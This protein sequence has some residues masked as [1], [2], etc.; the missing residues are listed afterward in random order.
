MKKTSHQDL[1]QSLTRRKKF[2]FFVITVTL[3]VILALV[4]GE[5]ILQVVFIPGIGYHSY[6]YDDLTGG[7]HFPNSTILFRRSGLSEVRRR[8]NAWGYVDNDHQIVKAS[9]ITRI[10]FFGDSYT[11]AIQVPLEDTFFRL[12]E[13]T[14]NTDDLSP[15]TECLAFGCTGNSMLQAYLESTR[16]ADF[17]DLDWVV[18][19]FVENDLGDQ[20]PIIKKSDN[21]PYPY[22]EGDSF[23]VDYSFRDRYSNKGSRSHRFAQY[24]KTKSLLLSTVVER[25]RLL[26]RRGIKLR[27]TEEE[28]RMAEKTEKRR[29]PGPDMVPSSW[30]DTLVSQAVDLGERI[31]KKW[32][33]EM[34]TSKRPFVVL[35]V[36]REQEINTP[37]SEQDSW[38]AWLVDTCR[39]NN[40]PFIDPS[41]RLSIE[42]DRGNNV[43][44]DHLTPRGHTAMAAS[45][46]DYYR[47]QRRY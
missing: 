47:N 3:S 44:G 7:R 6:Y 39:Q 4:L 14:L 26:K 21:I 24:L 16:W 28:M 8:T 40:I 1:G 45:F 33:R 35:Y 43:F 37:Y 30:P 36:P 25:L 2:L 32:A 29:I 38:A 17:F 27:V 22:A 11:E 19:V 12:I 34:R 42:R 20:I 5:V 13:D 10:G 46:V 18:Y 15:K 23:G 41:S 31:M 9:G